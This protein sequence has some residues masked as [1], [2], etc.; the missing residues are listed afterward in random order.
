MKNLGNDYCVEVVK[1]IFDDKL[2]W[3][4]FRINGV[5]QEGNILISLGMSLLVD[6]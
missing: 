1:V 5:K 4:E 6:Y 2:V 3:I